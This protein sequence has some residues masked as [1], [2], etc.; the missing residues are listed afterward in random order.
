MAI[1][2]PKVEIGF[3]L[4][5]SPIGPFF[6]LNDDV[7][8]RLDNTEFRLGGTIFYDVTDRVR[9]LSI[10]RGKGRRFTDFPAGQ[11]VVEFN[12]HDRAFDPEYSAS[13]FAGNIIPRREIKVSAGTAIQFTGW[14]DDWNL[15]YTPDG[16]SIA[17]AAA[18]DATTILAKQTL[19]AGT[20]TQELTS[21]R[22]NTALTDAGWASE[23]R[24]IQ[25]GTVEVGTQE[26][27]ANQNALS[28]LE[29]VTRTEAGLLFVD[30][31]GR[32]AFR[33]RRQAPSSASLVTFDQSSGIPYQAI[34]ITYG[35]ELLYNR[36]T[37][38]NIGG[39]TAT[40]SSVSSQNE[41]GVREYSQ[42]DLLGA[43]DAQS[44][45]LA[46]Y[47]ADLYSEPE[48]RIDALEIATEDL[49]AGQQEDV[50]G[51]EIGDV[52][53]VSF[54]PNNIGDPIVK[55]VQVIKVDHAVTTSFHKTTLG[56]QEIK[57]LLLVLDDAVFGKLDEAYL[58]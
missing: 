8:G 38:A 15:T 49:T 30:K 9:S 31:S 25:T 13:P 29:Q 28:Y 58:G 2:T 56:F 48:Y 7:A 17:D 32:V 3:D 41:Y 53:Q 43:T 40:A 21:T 4:T 34:G 27:E 46:V 23:L 18:L 52:C 36:V 6:R 10:S 47:Y 22:V 24:D 57:Y 42:T 44:I 45:D 5:D 55:Y 54:T 12:N 33:P 11:A 50:L 16:N 1:P 37:I 39:G 20:P 26:I 14:V 35:S 51:L 19:T